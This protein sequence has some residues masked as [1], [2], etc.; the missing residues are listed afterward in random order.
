MFVRVFN[1]TDGKNMYIPDTVAIRQADRDGNER[2]SIKD[3]SSGVDYGA[4]TFIPGSNHHY[5]S[6]YLSIL[7]D[8]CPQ[9]QKYIAL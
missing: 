3:I 2:H 4:V 6:I 8:S 1:A 7:N 9:V 5:I